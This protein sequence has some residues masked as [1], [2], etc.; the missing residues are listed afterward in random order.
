MRIAFFTDSYLP[1]LHGVSISIETFKKN[2]ENL[3]HEVYIFCPDLEK[4]VTKDK[5]YDFYSITIFK[6]P[7]IKLALPFLPKFDIKKLFEIK[8][9]ICHSHTPF[10]LGLLAKMVSKIKK[11]PL[12]Y[13]HHT[14]YIDYAKYYLKEGIITPKIAKLIVKSYANNS[15]AVISPSF[16]I[17]KELKTYGVNKKIYVLPTGVNLDIFKPDE[18]I[19]FE[20]RKKLKLDSKVKV[21]LLVCR[22][23]KEKNLDFIIKVMDILNKFENIYF[24]IVGDGPFLKEMKSITKSLDLKRVTFTGQVPHSEVHLYYKISDIFIF[25]SH[26][27]T[28]AITILEALASG[29]PIVALDDEIY[30]NIVFNNKNGFLIR[31]NS[32]TE[33]SRKILTLI[34]NKNLYDRFR[35]F[36]LKIAK[37]YSDKNQTFKLL[38]IYKK[39]IKNFK[40]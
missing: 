39:T 11:I 40:K 8:A 13:T 21:L 7:K 17:K 23:G 24:L 29:L 31:S 19:Y 33:F 15:N 35:K 3:G 22:I 10:S 12:I 37:N 9:D 36:A 18:K 6:N 26:T 5:I 30:K 32:A 34:E 2:L 25:S 28:Q 14:Q 16:K 4:K 27:D 38:Q 1:T 20:F